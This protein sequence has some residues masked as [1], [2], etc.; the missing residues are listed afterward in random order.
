MHLFTGGVASTESRMMNMIRSIC[1]AFIISGNTV[2]VSASYPTL[3]TNNIIV[4]HNTQL[5]G[6]T[7]LTN[8]NVVGNA[9]LAGTITV[10]G[11]DTS[12]GN[13]SLLTCVGRD[14]SELSTVFSVGNDGSLFNPIIRQ[15]QDTLLI[16]KPSVGDLKWSATSTDIYGWLVCDGRPLSITDYHLLFAVIG[17]T[18]GGGEGVFMLPDPRGRVMGVPD[19]DA[20]TQGVSTGNSSHALTTTE[21]PSHSHSI[22]IDSAGS[23]SHNYQDA[24]FAENRGAGTNVFGTSAHCDN[25]NDF[26]WRTANGSCSDSPQDL[27]TS[28]AGGHTHTAT[29]N[30]TGSGGS[31]GLLQPTLFIGNVLIF[32]GKQD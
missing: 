18:Y 30:S 24:Y 1:D 13:S 6:N 28:S 31:F 19:G 8:G 22:T 11:P 7:T 14:G 4:R 21:L 16:S 9:T 32:S 17:Y 2:Q 23:H 25:D 12:N 15:I 3:E 26:K 29:I 20:Y 27:A 5:R 10:I